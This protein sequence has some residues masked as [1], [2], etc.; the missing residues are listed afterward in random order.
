MIIKQILCA[1]SLLLLAAPALALM[2]PQRINFQG[3]LINPS[4]NN[5]QAGPVGLT[6][7]IYNVPT[8][9]SSL[10]TETQN[11]VPLNNGVFSVE[12]G[13]VTGLSRELFLGASVYLG[14]TVV[15]DAGG[16]ML[17]RQNL[18]MS[19]YAFSASQ[20]SDNTDVR[21]IAGAIYSTF[22]SAGN[23]AV[24]AGVSGS[25]GSFTNGVTASSGTFFA[26]G[27]AQYS[28]TTSSGINMNLGTLD[29]T[30]SDGINAQGT[31]IVAS[32]GVFTGSGAAVYSITT[33]SGILVNSGTLDVN[34]SG[35][36]TNLYGLTSATGA[37][38]SWVTAS[39]ATLSATG[40]GTGY[41]LTVSSGISMMNGTLDVNGGGGITNSYGLVT[42]TLVFTNSATDP[43]A[44]TKG[45]FYFN[46][47]SSTLKMYNGAS[48]GWLYAQPL[49]QTAR[50]TN[51]TAATA[52]KAAANVVLIS[53]LYLPGPMVVNVLIA[54]ETTALS[55]AG[56][57][58][59]YNSTGGFVL[60]G[61]LPAGAGPQ[62]VAPT[63]TGIAR[64]LP[65]GQYY[66]AATWNSTTGVLGGD[67]LAVAGAVPRS[68]SL[69]TGGAA[70]P[71]TIAPASITNLTFNYFFGVSQ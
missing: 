55:V 41:G 59:I 28:I 24:P 56:Q 34:G 13:T 43:V 35:G 31:G 17:P 53:P 22:T 48:W 27:P 47:S 39:S 71:A 67:S 23:F 70:L 69:T 65:P 9:G 45:M 11:S 62:S 32:T 5:P 60:S 40:S 10:Y 30:G 26:S 2:Q 66:M 1:A 14:V 54:R 64:F 51:N 46:S 57:I 36:I 52:A 50:T 44:A 63:Q 29:L 3:K 6:F 8:G 25:S 20:L 68:G 37:F 7:N 21:L 4:T 19:A 18:V 15:G 42:S 16:E 33:T 49:V 61:T 38:S 12:I 58:G